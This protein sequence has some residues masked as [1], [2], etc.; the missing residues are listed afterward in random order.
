MLENFLVQI[1]SCCPWFPEERTLETLGKFG[2]VL[3]TTQTD[4]I[5]LWIWVI[6]KDAID[7]KKDKVALQMLATAQEQL[8]ELHQEH[9]SE[10]TFSE[11]GSLNNE[12]EK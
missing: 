1:D 8:E 4:F 2:E 12:S 5:T 3:R 7:N 6:I 11:E 9:L 10:R